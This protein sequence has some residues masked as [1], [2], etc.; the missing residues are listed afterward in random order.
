[1]FPESFITP[2]ATQF[3]V[4]LIKQL[5]PSKVWNMGS[6]IYVYVVIIKRAYF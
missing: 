5:F 1:M 2:F 6:I 3:T 4:W